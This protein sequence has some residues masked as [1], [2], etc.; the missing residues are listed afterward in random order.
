MTVRGY[1]VKKG[2]EPD[3]RHAELVE[4]EV[5]II[6]DAIEKLNA[7]LKQVGFND[8]TSETKL[9]NLCDS[10]VLL[11]KSGLSAADEEAAISTIASITEKSYNEISASIGHIKDMLNEYYRLPADP[12]LGLN[13]SGLISHQMLTS[14]LATSSLISEVNSETDEVS[15]TESIAVFRAAALFYIFG[16]PGKGNWDGDTAARR[17]K[18]LLDGVVNES[19]QSEILA[20]IEDDQDDD[21]G[22]S[23]IEKSS[24]YGLSYSSIKKTAAAVLDKSSSHEADDFEDESVWLSMDEEEMEPLL[25]SFLSSMK[26]PE[27]LEEERE[28]ELSVLFSDISGIQHFIENTDRLPQMK[29]ASSII[30]G[31]M[32]D[33]RTL[34][35]AGMPS[36]Y[37]ILRDTGIPLEAV[38]S[39]GGG[40][41][42]LLTPT[43][44]ADY[45]VDRLAQGIREATG[46]L[47]MVAAY[48]SF[49]VTDASGNLSQDSLIT[50][51]NQAR[52]K[53]IQMKNDLTATK[54]KLI[55][56]GIEL[57]CE[58]CGSAP[59]SELFTVGDNERTY[60]S[61]CKRVHD[62]G[63]R[64]SFR[65][66]FQDYQPNAS[67]L[68]GYGWDTFSEHILDFL[69]GND[70]MRNIEAS[71]KADLAMIKADANLAGAFISNVPSLSALIEK[72]MLLTNELQGTVLDAF[73]WLKQVTKKELDELGVT[74]SKEESEKLGL[75]LQLG[76]MYV[77]GD[78]LMLLCPASYCIPLALRIAQTFY[79]RLGGELS[80]S[81]GIISFPTH[82]P[83]RL[84][85]QAAESLLSYCKEVSRPFAIEGKDPMGVLDFEVMKGS[86][87][88]PSDLKTVH[89]FRRRNNLTQRPLILDDMKHPV[90]SSV[91][92]YGKGDPMRAIAQASIRYEAYRKN[93]IE[94]DASGL[95]D[96]WKA[97]SEIV[98]NMDIQETPGKLASYDASKGRGVSFS[99]YM[100]GRSE[101][102][103][104]AGETYG[105]IGLLALGDEED[106][107]GVLDAR[108]LARLMMG[109]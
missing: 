26:P 52:D 9:W 43:P 18:S 4:N 78:D 73:D 29:G 94:E 11:L 16:R 89:D 14:G 107:I 46:K 20:V 40:N 85:I 17:I 87:N 71:K 61:D 74:E 108:T 90:L 92:S 30:D 97:S 31:Y 106:R 75:R 56:Y 98:Q 33:V 63:L 50:H 7:A 99:V 72:N 5:R 83:I 80:M 96:F 47:R 86:L 101:T 53:T 81:L 12:R 69:A 55:D 67:K 88:A 37:S 104:R 76:M 22:R 91:V 25:R 79:E 36:L 58:S 42:I 3:N 103:A 59:A 23:R 19:L 38:I 13:L 48:S 49:S 32:K 105:K 70:A 64:E 109:G 1:Y 68:L 77:G 102:K 65:N 8:I 39:S 6:S 15:I 21:K 27:S 2:E 62:Y 93:M 24:Q 35:K 34:R 54:G 95:E 82:E 60:C 66:T 28:G 45:L 41:I 10:F 51:L 44:L 57:R 100:A 84:M